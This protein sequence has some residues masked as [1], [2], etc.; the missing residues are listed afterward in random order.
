MALILHGYGRRGVSRW[1]GT[2]PLP[3]SFLRLAERIRQ[4]LHLLPSEMELPW[5]DAEGMHLP[6]ETQVL[7]LNAAGIRDEVD[8]MI[9]LEVKNW[10][11]P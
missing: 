8:D 11:Y 3:R 10:K 5:D 2:S 6:A 9:L 1:L 7:I 4:V